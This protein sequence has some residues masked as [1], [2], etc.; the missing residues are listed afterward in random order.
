[1]VERHRGAWRILHATSLTRIAQW[2]G[3]LEVYEQQTAFMRAQRRA[4]HAYLE[5]FLEPSIREE[6]IYDVEHAEVDPWIPF[7]YGDLGTLGR[8]LMAA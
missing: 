7:G 5:R 4:W 8:H 3:V 1:M 6:D 2:L